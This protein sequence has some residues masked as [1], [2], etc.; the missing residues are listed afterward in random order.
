ML[1]EN[2]LK[3]VLILSEKKVTE[4]SQIQHSEKASFQGFLVCAD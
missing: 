4:N 3:T 1:S 2:S